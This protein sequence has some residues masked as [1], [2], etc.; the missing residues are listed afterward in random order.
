LLFSVSGVPLKDTGYEIWD[1]N[2]PNNAGGNESCMSVKV[3][4]GLNDISCDLKLA[5]MCEKEIDF[6]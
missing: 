1:I 5:F 4:G 3:T 6:N 2:E